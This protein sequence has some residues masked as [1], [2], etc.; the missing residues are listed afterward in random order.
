MLLFDFIKQDGSFNKKRWLK[1]Y[2]RCYTRM[3]TFIWCCY[4]T[5]FLKQSL[6]LLLNSVLGCCLWIG[7][8]CVLSIHIIFEKMTVIGQT[9]QD[10]KCVGV[11]VIVGV[12]I[13]LSRVVSK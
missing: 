12:S 10:L 4:K 9:S 7:G 3:T 1:I 5:P 8:K 13:E 11:V 6:V 2:Y